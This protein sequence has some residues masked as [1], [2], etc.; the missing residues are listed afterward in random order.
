MIYLLEE[1]LHAPRDGDGGRTVHGHDHCDQACDR[2]VMVDRATASGQ[3]TAT[4]TGSHRQASYRRDDGSTVKSKPVSLIMI[5]GANL[6][7]HDS[8]MDR[9][10]SI[11]L[12]TRELVQSE[13]LRNNC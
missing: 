8:V 1:L 2:E 13:N 10:C 5:F 4:G 9:S 6:E 11:N 12:V 7:R 3:G